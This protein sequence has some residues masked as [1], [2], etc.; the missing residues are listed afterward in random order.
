M[1]LFEPNEN[2]L[3]QGNITVVVACKNEEEFLPRLLSS[4]SGQ[5]YENFELVLVNDHS[6]DNTGMIMENAKSIFPSIQLI[7][8]V[9]FGKKNALKEG[10]LNSKNDFIIT[11][12]ADC[13]P[14][15]KWIETILRFSNNFPSDFCLLYTSPSPRD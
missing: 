6:T 9:G 1:T 8:A 3:I 4:L 2:E 10:I 13:S 5:S 14:V 15:K 12:D 7:N 11:I